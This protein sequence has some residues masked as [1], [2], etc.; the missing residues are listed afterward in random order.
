MKKEL[1]KQEMQ[2]VQGGAT[3]L[4]VQLLK[5]QTNSTS[6]ST[7]AVWEADFWCKQHP[8]FPRCPTPNPVRPMPP[9]QTMRYPSDSDSDKSTL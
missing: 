5:T 2:Q 1:S 9:M 7:K 4:W 3:P 8:E 6:Q